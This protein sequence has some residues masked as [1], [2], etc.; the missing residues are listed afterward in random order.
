MPFDRILRVSRPS[1]D[2]PF[3]SDAGTVTLRTAGPY[4][5]RDVSTLAQRIM[6]VEALIDGQPA[7]EGTEIA[8]EIDQPGA[9]TI[10]GFDFGFTRFAAEDTPFKFGSSAI[11]SEFGAGLRTFTLL[12]GNNGLAGTNDEIVRDIMWWN[13]CA[14][15]A[16]AL[17]T[18][19][20]ETR[21]P[22]T[23]FGGS[24]RGRQGRE[25]VVYY[26]DTATQRNPDYPTGNPSVEIERINGGNFEGRA[27]RA[28]QD[29]IDA[30]ALE[31]PPSGSRAWVESVIE[32]TIAPNYAV[33]WLTEPMARAVPRHSDISIGGLFSDAG[34]VWAELDSYQTAENIQDDGTLETVQISRWR[35]RDRQPVA[36]TPADRIEDDSGIVWEITGVDADPDGHAGFINCERS[37]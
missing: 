12:T 30:I 13:E 25:T 27:P 20:N 19:P 14:R 18:V 32:F 11:A 16:S 37:L 6:V 8:G 5:S 9:V 15:F 24:I 2:L 10:G 26:A 35:V 29:A 21:Y 4:W 28:A 36:I 3:I 33:L 17:V 31:K 34:A 22:A 23:L 1:S 7:A